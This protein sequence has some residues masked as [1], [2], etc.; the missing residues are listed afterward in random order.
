[1][2]AA[3]QKPIEEILKFF[4]PGEKVFVVGCDNCAAKCR[5]RG[6]LRRTTWQTN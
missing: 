5:S 3:I 4:K 2:H 6:Y 1:M